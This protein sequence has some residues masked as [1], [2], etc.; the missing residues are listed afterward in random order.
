MRLIA[1]ALFLALAVPA[2]AVDL[3]LDKLTKNQEVD[4]FRVNAV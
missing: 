1:A 2:F 4:G 3:D